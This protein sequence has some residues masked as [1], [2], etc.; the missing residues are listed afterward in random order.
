VRAGAPFR[1]VR[2]PE[3]DRA[4]A[5][6][7]LDEQLILVGHVVGVH[8]RSERRANARRER[9]VLVRDRK[10]VQRPE[11]LAAR[12]RVVGAASP[13]RCAF[14]CQRHDRV[15]GR[16]DL[17]DAR[18]MDVE[19]LAR[20]ELTRADHRRELGRASSPERIRHMVM[21]REPFGPQH[22]GRLAGGD[23]RRT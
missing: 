11:E 5:A 19:E 13:L 2:L 4:G 16:V 8:W 23:R 12:E 6:D 9:E 21:L 1:R 15:D 14:G 10:S 7:A 18:E 17:V 20:R 3:H 22:P